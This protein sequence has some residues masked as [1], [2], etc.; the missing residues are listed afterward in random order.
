MRRFFSFFAVLLICVPAAFFVLLG[1]VAL[2][3]SGSDV[4]FT[5]KRIGHRGKLFS[6]YKL[7]T[8]EDG[9]VTKVGRILRRTSVDE[10]PQLW[11]V[12]RG[13][14]NI[15]GPRPLMPHERMEYGGTLY[16][17]RLPGLTGLWQVMDH[18]SDLK[19]RGELDNW[20]IIN[21]TWWTDVMIIINTPL[22]M[23][24]NS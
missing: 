23:L 9:V 2:K 4:F 11:N 24:T 17:T 16:E 1:A 5:Q 15:V 18:G 19:R 14:M 3:L 20:Y 7:K 8:M 12:I 21:G 22:A 6:I 10:L 13:D